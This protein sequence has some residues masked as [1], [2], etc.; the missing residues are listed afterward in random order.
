MAEWFVKG[1]LARLLDPSDALARALLAD[2]TFFIVPN[3]NPDGSVR[4]FLR[5]NASGCNLNR[6]WAPTGEY[7]APTLERSPEVFH[8]LAECDRVGCDL[9]ID[10]HGDEELP[11]NFVSG[12]EGCPVW[13]PRL[14]G[15]QRHFCEAWKRANPDF[16]TV[17]GYS[18]D[19]PLSANLAMCSNQMAQRF[20]CLSLTFEMPFKDCIDARGTQVPWLHSQSERMGASALDAVAHVLPALR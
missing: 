15:L 2:A 17:V 8:V 10:V 9:F 13:G 12:M 5:T 20:D 19:E 1:L 3:M 6:E 4:G 18:L 16:Q 7:H 14:E 11:H